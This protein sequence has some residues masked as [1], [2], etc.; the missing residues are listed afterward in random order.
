MAESV[1]WEYEAFDPCGNACGR[2]SRGASITVPFADTVAKGVLFA[3]A[4]V[5]TTHHV[6]KAVR[7]ARMSAT[8]VTP[9]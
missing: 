9:L 7:I 5:V 4:M 8:A 3:A 6:D 2:E 1:A